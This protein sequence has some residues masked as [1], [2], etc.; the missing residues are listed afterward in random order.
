MNLGLQIITT[1]M[2]LQTVSQIMTKGHGV[3][4]E[5]QQKWVLLC[6]YFCKDFSLPV[7]CAK[8]EGVLAC[9]FRSLWGSLLEQIS[10]PF[11]PC[12]CHKCLK[13]VLSGKHMIQVVH[14]LHTFTYRPNRKVCGAGCANAE[15]SQT[16]KDI[17]VV[18][19]QCC[20]VGAP[21]CPVLYAIILCLRIYNISVS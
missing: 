11:Y 5:P 20:N 4:P 13:A 15:V 6:F 16:D 1:D 8:S 18:A 10:L 9:Y 21:W 19:N 3:N 17:C 7:D 2:T 14:F 12:S